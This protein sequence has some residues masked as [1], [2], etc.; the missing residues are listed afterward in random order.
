M[1]Y[2]S[3]IGSTERLSL[4]GTSH[5]ENTRTASLLAP[6]LKNK[7]QSFDSK[8][9]GVAASDR[10]KAFKK[11]QFFT[12]FSSVNPLDCSIWKSHRPL[13]TF[14][15]ITYTTFEYKAVYLSGIIPMSHW[16][17]AYPGRA[18]EPRVET[19]TAFRA[20]TRAPPLKFVRSHSFHP[21]LSINLLN[22]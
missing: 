1:L 10:L 2:D 5:S 18:V 13:R 20:S 4:N 3:R 15:I 7:K 8:L 22:Q 9:T 16:T 21:L 11:V 19:S 14:P 6:L 17:L 12:P